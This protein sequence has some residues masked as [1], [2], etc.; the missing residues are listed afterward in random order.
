RIRKVGAVGLGSGALAAYGRSGRQFTFYEIDPAMARIAADPRYFTFLH[1]S[2]ARTRVV[3]GDGRLEL[4]KAPPHSDDLIVLDA[5]SSDSVPVH[6]LTR[7][8]V[9]LYL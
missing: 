9:Q 3:I 7:E 1:D 4:A 5:F 2:R 6:L 8:A